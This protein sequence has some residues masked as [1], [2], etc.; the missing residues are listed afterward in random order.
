MM[1]VNILGTDYKITKKKYDEDA[2][3]EKLECCGYCD[4]VTKEIIHCDMNTYPNYESESSEYI[5]GVERSTL[6]HEVIHAFLSE[7]GLEQSTLSVDSW[8]RNEEMVDWFALQSP[9]IFKAFMN[10]GV[11]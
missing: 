9:K 5:T 6:R 11:I 1:K 8:A 10:A 3:F 2:D 7:S 4:S